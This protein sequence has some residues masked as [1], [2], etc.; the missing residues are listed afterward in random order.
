[1]LLLSSIR[2]LI[3]TATVGV[4]TEFVVWKGDWGVTWAYNL[5]VLIENYFFNCLRIPHEA[6][7]S[8]HGVIVD[9]PREERFVVKWLCDLVSNVFFVKPFLLLWSLILKT[10]HLWLVHLSV[11]CPM[12]EWRL[13]N[14]A[15]AVFKI[16]L[17]ELAFILILFDFK[18]QINVTYFCVVVAFL[19]HIQWVFHL[20]VVKMSCTVKSRASLRYLRI[21]HKWGMCT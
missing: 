11:Y 1:M 9:H 15:F 6:T 7:R 17:D 14:E 16:Q 4:L 8:H 19:E 5:L 18:F 20:V 12:R 13:S 21:R 3:L 2:C 10:I